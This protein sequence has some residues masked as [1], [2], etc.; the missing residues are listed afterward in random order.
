MSCVGRSKVTV[1]NATVWSLLMSVAPPAAKGDTMFD[2][3]GTFASLAS[4]SS[5]RACT[6]GS[7][8]L[9]PDDV[10]KTTCSTSPDTFGETACRSWIASVDWVFGRE[11]LFENALPADRES[12]V[13]TITA[14]T[15]NTTTYRRRRTHH[16]AIG[17]NLRHSSV[18][19]SRPPRVRQ[20]WDV[21]YGRTTV[22]RL[23]I[24]RAPTAAGGTTA[25]ARLVGAALLARDGT[26]ASRSP[27]G[28]GA[29]VGATGG[30][31][32]PR[33]SSI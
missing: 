31:P 6:P 4:I 13:T 8:T 10:P 3:F 22:R 17:R 25:Q 5:M 29:S 23:G 16:L 28:A 12:S 1:A 26:S 11:K 32:T 2:T 15:Q 18:S 24:D 7:V 14:V 19:P 27:S 20:Q 30:V 9:V 21:P 33:R